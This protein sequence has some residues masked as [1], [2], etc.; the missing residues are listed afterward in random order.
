MPRTKDAELVELIRSGMCDCIPF[1][2]RLDDQLQAFRQSCA[3]RYARI[4]ATSQLCC[5]APSDVGQVWF[6]LSGAIDRMAAHPGYYQKLLAEK[7]GQRNQ[8]SAQIEKVRAPS[9]VRLV[10]SL[11]EA[12]FAPDVPRP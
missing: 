8:Y 10:S 11:E 3:A 9:G 4:G 12:G 2:P 6:I 7:E 1:Q 5:S